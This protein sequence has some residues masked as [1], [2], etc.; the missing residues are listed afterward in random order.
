MK[1]LGDHR[2]LSPLIAHINQ[3]SGSIGTERR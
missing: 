3:L 2:K 1:D